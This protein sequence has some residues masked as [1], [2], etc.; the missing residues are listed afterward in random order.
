MEPTTY[1]AE[2]QL[3]IFCARQSNLPTRAAGLRGIGILGFHTIIMTISKKEK[4]KEEANPRQVRGEIHF[5]YWFEDK[6]LGRY[7][8]L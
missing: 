6:V 3:L 8:Q 7:W 5:C 4:V 2:L 1:A